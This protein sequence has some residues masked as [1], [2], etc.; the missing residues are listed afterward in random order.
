[1][2]V[3]S[4]DSEARFTGN[5]STVSFPTSI[6]VFADTDIVVRTINNSTDLVDDTL[7][8]NDAGALGYSVTFDTG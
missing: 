5:G 1:M 4:T 6:K 8:L 7:V 3:S 2:T